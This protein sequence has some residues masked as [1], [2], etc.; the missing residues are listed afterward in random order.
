MFFAAPYGQNLTLFFTLSFQELATQLVGILRSH[1][2]IEDD[3]DPYQVDR[4]VVG[5]LGLL[6]I[7]VRAAPAVRDKVCPGHFSALLPPKQLL[8]VGHEDHQATRTTAEGDLMRD[9]FDLC[10]F[11]IP[12]PKASAEMR[13]QEGELPKCKTQR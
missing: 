13:K 3:D 12:S 5:V 8:D 7:L 4:I 1:V 6:R 11:S 2:S 9:V 10:L